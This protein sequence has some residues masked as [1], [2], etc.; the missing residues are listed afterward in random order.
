[1]IQWRGGR[2]WSVP[3]AGMQHADGRF[4]CAAGAPLPAP[5]VFSFVVACHACLGLSSRYLKDVKVGGQMSLAQA[6][7]GQLGPKLQ[8]QVGAPNAVGEG[9][10]AWSLCSC[11]MKV[12]EVGGQ[13]GQA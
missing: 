10:A 6:L 5:T 11:F 2:A 8:S 4:C 13:P 12:L 1:M 3:L 7:A 9:G